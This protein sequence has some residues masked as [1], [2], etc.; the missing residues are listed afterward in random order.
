MEEIIRLFM[1]NEIKALVA[2]VAF[3][4]GFDKPDIGFVVH[5]QKPGNLVAY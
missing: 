2:T 1:N 4:M 5:F 3:G